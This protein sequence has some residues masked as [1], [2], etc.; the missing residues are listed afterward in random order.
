MDKHESHVVVET[1]TPLK[2]IYRTFVT[3]S[4][5]DTFNYDFNFFYL[6]ILS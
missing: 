3:S 1:E 5:A 2:H 6:K 4:R